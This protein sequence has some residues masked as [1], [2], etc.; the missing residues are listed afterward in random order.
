MIVNEL[1]CLEN[2]KV[3]FE[4][5]VYMVMIL[6]TTVFHLPYVSG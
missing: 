1:I 3:I 5:D 6:L 2:R 4:T